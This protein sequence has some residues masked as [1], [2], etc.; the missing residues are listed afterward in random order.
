MIILQAISGKE[1]VLNCD[2]IE[3]IEAIPDTKITL[4]TGKYMLVKNTPE[5]IIEKT[6]AYNKTIFGGKKMVHVVTNEETGE[7]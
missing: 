4:V 6:I 3:T 7:T 5:E 1:I 2:L